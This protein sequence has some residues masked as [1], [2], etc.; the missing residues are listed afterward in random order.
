MRQTQKTY[1]FITEVN[2]YSPWKNEV[3]T[4]TILMQS[5]QMAQSSLTDYLKQI[6]STM[7]FAFI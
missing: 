5:G 3:Y 6:K 2:L 7:L 1:T 4:T